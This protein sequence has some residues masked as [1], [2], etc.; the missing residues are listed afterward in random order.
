MFAD[1]NNKD[2]EKV[3]ASGPGGKTVNRSKVI[4]ECMKSPTSTIYKKESKITP[5]NEPEDIQK[6]DE[7]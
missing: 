6:K 1:D 5:K 3:N 7:S 2:G 4:L